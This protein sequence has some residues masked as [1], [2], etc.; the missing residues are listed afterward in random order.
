M[1]KVNFK[2]IATVW[3]DKLEKQVKVVVGEF[4]RISNANLFKRAYEAHY[5][6][7]TELVYG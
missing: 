5:N 6:V 2:V 4:D 7:E 3:D 1:E